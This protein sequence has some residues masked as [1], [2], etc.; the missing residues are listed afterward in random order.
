MPTPTSATVSKCTV[1]P[2]WRPPVRVTETVA[3]VVTDVGSVVEYVAALN[4]MTDC[5]AKP[6]LT[7]RG[8]SMSTSHVVPTPPH[9][10]PQPVKNDPAAG[11]AVNVTPVPAS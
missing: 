11:V 4:L 9:A 6:A 1:T 7:L 2:A 10:P 5:S 3:F 8:W